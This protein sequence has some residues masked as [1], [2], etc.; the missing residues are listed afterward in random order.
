[1][2][3]TPLFIGFI[4]PLY[5]VIMI[6]ALLL[7]LYASAKT[8]S[9]FSKYSRVGNSSGLSGA[10]AA[11]AML[12]A[13]GLTVVGSAQQA[14]GM[15]NAVAI[16]SV[17]GFLTDHYDP[18]ERVLRLSPEVGAGRSLSAVGVACHEAGHA[19]QH[20]RGYAPL[21][22]RSAMVPVTQFGSYAYLPL[23]ILG[24]ILGVASTA[25]S[26]FLNL[27]IVAFSAIVLFQLV[28]LPVEFDASKRARVALS[29]MGV[30]ARGDEERGV[31]NVLNAAALTY[32]AAAVLAIG[33]L[34]YFLIIASQ[35]R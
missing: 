11:A 18:R 35:Q 13:Q 23:I 5:I 17:R 3:L 19:L 21:A 32:V 29:E 1:M 33:Q 2:T 15:E 20:A 28:T 14:K 30:I 26:F 7:G 8:K 6:P 22:I 31:A 34:I 25:G 12:R 10:E 9:A 16:E 24:I 4:D 27:G